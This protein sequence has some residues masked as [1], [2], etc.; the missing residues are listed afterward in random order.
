MRTWRCQQCLRWIDY[1]SEK[2]T[3]IAKACVWYGEISH[4]NYTGII[5]RPPWHIAKRG[6]PSYNRGPLIATFQYCGAC[7]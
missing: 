6:E 7:K 3:L 5:G 4:E 1:D 2:P